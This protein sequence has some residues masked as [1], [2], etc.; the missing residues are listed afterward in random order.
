MRISLRLRHPRLTPLF[1]VYLGAMSTVGTAQQYD[2]EKDDAT[3]SEAVETVIVTARRSQ[4]VRVRPR[5]VM[6]G[7]RPNQY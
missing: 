2:A 3:N 7:P 5:D 6:G 1:A 4:A